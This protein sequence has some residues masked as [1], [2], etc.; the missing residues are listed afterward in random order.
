MILNDYSLLALAYKCFSSLTFMP[1]L[2]FTLLQFFLQLASLCNPDWPPNHFVAKACQEHMNL[3]LPSP[4]GSDHRCEPSHT[5][6]LFFPPMIQTIRRK[7][8]EKNN[9]FRTYKLNGWQ[10]YSVHHF[11][12][13]SWVSWGWECVQCLCL[14]ALESD[15]MVWIWGLS[16]YVTLGKFLQPGTSESTKENIDMIRL[17][18]WGCW[19]NMSLCHRRLIFANTWYIVKG[20]GNT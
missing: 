11:Q 18:S 16:I 12:H 9:P 13:S 3:L 4:R 1:R 20:S 15:A 10:H 14:W 19:E 17:T 2:Y 7:R 8:E 6:E 5:A